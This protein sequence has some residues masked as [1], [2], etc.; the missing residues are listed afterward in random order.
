MTMIIQCSKTDACFSLIDLLKSLEVMLQKIN[1]VFHVFLHLKKLRMRLVTSLILRRFQKNM[2]N[3]FQ[4]SFKVSRDLEFR[5]IS[6]NL[7]STKI[8]LVARISSYSTQN[9]TN[10]D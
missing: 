8:R 5:K 7:Q 3:C 6:I 10:L 2:M 4:S 1:I 9:D